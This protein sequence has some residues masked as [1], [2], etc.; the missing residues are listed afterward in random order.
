MQRS[1]AAL[2]IDFTRQK[3]PNVVFDIS[4]RCG[5][6]RAGMPDNRGGLQYCLKSGHGS[7]LSGFDSRLM[8]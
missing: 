2:H 4:M 7:R 6:V 3:K 5:K 8:S 1:V